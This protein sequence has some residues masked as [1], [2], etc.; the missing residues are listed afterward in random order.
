MKTQEHES[1]VERSFKPARPPA[2]AAA[3][4]AAAVA[5]TSFAFLVFGPLSDQRVFALA[6][7]QVVGGAGEAEAL[8]R[9]V[10]PTRKAVAASDAALPQRVARGGGSGFDARLATE[11]ASP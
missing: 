6:G 10:G 11:M 4:I 9:F 3:G 7:V 5:I 8:E 1:A 2:R